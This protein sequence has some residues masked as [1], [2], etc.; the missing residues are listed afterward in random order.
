MAEGEIPFYADGAVLLSEGGIE[1]TFVYL[2]VPGEEVRCVELPTAM[3]RW[4]QVTAT[5][6]FLD[7]DGSPL[8]SVSS[9]LEVPCAQPDPNAA[10]TRP[11]ISL[12][13]P[14]RRGPGLVEAVLAD[15]NATRV[16]LIH[17]LR[18]TPRAGTARTLLSRPVLRGTFGLGGPLFL[19]GT[20]KLGELSSARGFRLGDADVMRNGLEPNPARG[21]GLFQ[22]NLLLYA[23]LYGCSEAEADL[24]LRVLAPADSTV[25]F[26]EQARVRPRWDRCGLVRQLDVTQLAAGAYVIEL[27]AR[28]VGIAAGEPASGPVRLHARF[29]VA[30][31]PDSWAQPITARM[32]EASLLMDPERW[33]RFVKLGTG[34]Q[35]AA[36]DSLWRSVRGGGSDPE[37][38]KALFRQ[39]AA[40]ADARFSGTRRGILT[41]RGRVFVNFGDPDEIHKQLAPQDEDLIYYFLRREIDDTEAGEAGGR[42]HRHPMDTSRYQVWYYINWGRPLFPQV[43]SQLR[44]GGGG[45]RFIFLDEMGTGDYRLIYT[46]LFGGFD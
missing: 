30:W 23:E 19:W 27:T 25:L 38:L 7:L 13:V 46:N 20:E 12:R 29:Q 44:G 2:A 45:L 34:Q 16:G 14:E 6:R 36:L 43:Q 24:G 21:Y 42:P 28:Q 26:E 15:R 22:P 41:D 4:M 40:T 8:A 37:E 31:D 32:E 3:G 35:E 18:S 11:I 39:R 10:F 9:D 1:E 17:Q 5:L 33:D